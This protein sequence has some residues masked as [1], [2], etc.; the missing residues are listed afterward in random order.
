MTFV[1]PFWD[2]CKYSSLSLVINFLLDF[3]LQVFLMNLL[4]TC[5]KYLEQVCQSVFGTFPTLLSRPF[6]VRCDETREIITYCAL[7][8]AFKGVINR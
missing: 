4:F 2:N 5:A 6:T 8:A 3:F 1:V 7:N